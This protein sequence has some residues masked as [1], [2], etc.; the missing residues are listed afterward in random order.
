MSRFK[1]AW[2]ALTGRLEPEV[3]EIVR[4]V[5]VL[6]DASIAT[7]YQV[8]RHNQNVDGEWITESD[9]Y[10][11]CEQAHAAHPNSAV[12]KTKGI[13]VGK[14]YWVAEKLKQAHVTPKPKRPKGSAR[15]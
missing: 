11:T 9:F 7:L 15:G 12:F 5:P 2:L 3:R 13:R 1:K 4:T 6:G 10:T 14:E 8:M